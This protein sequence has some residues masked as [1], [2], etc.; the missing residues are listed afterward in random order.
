MDELTFRQLKE[1]KY[2]HPQIT[3]VIADPKMMLEMVVDSISITE[4]GYDTVIDP[5]VYSFILK[6]FKEGIDMIDRKIEENGIKARMIVDVN[7]ENID[8]INTIKFHE[9]KHIDEIKGN[10]GIF[11]ERAYMVFIFHKES[12]QPDQTLWSN[13]KAL[14]DRQ[15][16]LFNKMWDIAIPL[17]TRTKE[18]EYQSIPDYQNSLTNAKEIKKQIDLLIQ[19]SRNELLLISSSKLLNL[20][21][22]T[23]DFLSQ[24]SVLL[25]RGVRIRIL[26]NNVDRDIKSK[27]NFINGLGLDQQ[28]EYEFSHLLNKYSEFTVISDGKS[29]L[30]CSIKPSNQMMGYFTTEESIIFVQEIVFEKYWNEVMSLKVATSD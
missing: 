16:D 17:S 22:L 28:I 25:K 12:E 15:Q 13:S 6:Y 8:F 21:I 2:R 1:S 29:M 26:S 30:R 24:I 23:T 27:F 19:Q 10:F 18:L 7:K 20:I 14:V 3:D 5:L 4:K 9:I 11:D